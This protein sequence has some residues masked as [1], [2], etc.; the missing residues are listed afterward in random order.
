[1]GELALRTKNIESQR[2]TSGV[3][4]SVPGGL[5]ACGRWGGRQIIDWPGRRAAGFSSQKLKR[6]PPP[7]NDP[8]PVQLLYRR[9]ALKPGVP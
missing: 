8:L 1:M 7:N 9:P 5:D 2:V 6:K 4:G 3:A